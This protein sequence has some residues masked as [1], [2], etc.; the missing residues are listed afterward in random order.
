MERIKKEGVVHDPF[1]RRK[2]MPVLPTH[3]MKKKEAELKNG[4]QDTKAGILSESTVSKAM[5]KQVFYFY[6]GKGGQGE[7]C[8][9]RVPES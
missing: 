1:T 5:V 4:S 6:K 9:E 3:V 2:T 7:C 8:E